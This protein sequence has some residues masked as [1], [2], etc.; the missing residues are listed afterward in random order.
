MPQSPNSDQNEYRTL[1]FWHDSL[2]ADLRPRS[3]LQGDLKADVVIVGAGYTGLW[4]AYY[5]HRLDP[6][7]DIVLLES[8]IA[9]FGASGRN[10]GWCASFLSGIDHWLNDPASRDGGLRLQRL[11]FDTV[12]EIGE[13]TDRESID[14]HFDHS[15]T[16]EVA[17]N[18]GQL[19]R[20]R[21]GYEAMAALGFSEDDFRWLDGG[22]LRRELAVEG[23]LGG[24][25]SAHTA[26]VHPARLARGLAEVV[27]RNGIRLLEHSPVVALGDNHAVTD[28]G[29]VRADTVIAATEGYSDSLPGMERCM[30]PVHSM[31]VVTEPLSDSQIEAT[32]FRRRYTFGNLDHM[33]TYG[34]LTADRR[35]AFG[36]RGSYHY[37]SGLRHFRPEEPE[38]DLVRRKLLT[39]F[40]GLENIRFSHA[41]GGAMG[42]SRSLRPSVNFDSRRRMGWAG[43][44]FGNGVGAAHLAGRTL[45]DLVLDR[46][47]PR[48]RTPWINPPESARRWEPEPLR[49]LGF[50]ATRLQKQLADRL[51]YRL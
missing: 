45:A 42:V 23:A 12:R 31:M 43:G 19:R 24:V 33:V 18:R 27:E 13:V 51:E 38:F 14:C 17:V 35:I 48:T 1:S 36:C 50:K 15:G 44:Y 8:E 37:G 29:R 6:G 16:L 26:A 28:R 30:I 20:A 47:T 46:D 3:P 25:H 4:T 32:G 40:P 10:G 34:Q 21:E 49:W 22:E 2:P 9:G 5:L 11:M 39:F 41:W 7:L